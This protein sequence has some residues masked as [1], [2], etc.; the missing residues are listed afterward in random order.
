M[1]CD[2]PSSIWLAGLRPSPAEVRR[3]HCCPGSTSTTASTDAAA[4]LRLKGSSR[5]ALTESPALSDCQLDR[6][7]CD[8]Q[9]LVDVD[10]LHDFGAD[11]ERA[12]PVVNAHQALFDEDLLRVAR[13]VQGRGELGAEHV[14]GRQA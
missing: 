9:L 1:P 5:S 10:G 8:P 14:D 13:G 12:D 3:A 4:S 2:T 11:D 6:V 7:P